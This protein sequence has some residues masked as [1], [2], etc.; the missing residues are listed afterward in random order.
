[1]IFPAGPRRQLSHHQNGQ[2]PNNFF[3]RPF[4]NP[5]LSQQ[6]SSS[7]LKTL[8]IKGV[9]GLSKTLDNVQNVINVVENTAPMIEKYGPLVKNIPTMYKMMKAINSTDIHE[10]VKPQDD[11]EE[12]EQ[13]KLS[14]YKD[15]S[16]KDSAEE[17]VVTKASTP[18]L[19]I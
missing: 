8:A 13:Q 3:G 16:V 9:D 11:A 19:Y 14:T 5:H 17:V 7:N 12:Q 6:S 15:E 18:K 2:R 1:M 4:A 10:E